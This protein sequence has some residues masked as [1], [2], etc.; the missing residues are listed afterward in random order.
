MTGGLALADSVVSL[1][2]IQ[3][4]IEGRPLVFL[5][6]CRSGAATQVRLQ[7][8]YLGSHALGLATSFIIGGAAA[9]IGNLWRLPDD[10][11]SQFPLTFYRELLEGAVLGEAL[12]RAKVTARGNYPSEIWWPSYSLF[13]DPSLK[14]RLS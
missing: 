6:A 3:R 10:K 2:D 11:A 7:P 14:W 12:R 4:H 9:C 8:A 5:N 13:G 1:D